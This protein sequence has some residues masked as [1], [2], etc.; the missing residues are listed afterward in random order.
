[1]P[2]HNPR[3]RLLLVFYN[4]PDGYPP[5]INSLRLL[6]RA[7]FAVEVYCRDDGHDWGVA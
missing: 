3:A 6:A 4:N 5:I 1:M 7:G 2:E